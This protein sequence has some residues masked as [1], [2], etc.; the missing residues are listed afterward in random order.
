MEIKDNSSSS[1]TYTGT[2][3]D[4]IPDNKDHVIIN[5]NITLQ[6]TSDADYMTINVSGS[7]NLNNYQLR[8][9]KN[10]GIL[11][12]NGNLNGVGTLR[13]ITNHRISGSGNYNNINFQR[14]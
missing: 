14:L 2:D 4:G 9:W 13:T 5:H 12:N 10:N 6:G 11:N 7:L 3:A 1:W 8:L